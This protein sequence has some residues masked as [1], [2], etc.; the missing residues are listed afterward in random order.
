MEDK[1]SI[2]NES[3]PLGQHAIGTDMAQTRLN[4]EMMGS[5]LI[6]ACCHTFSYRFQNWYQ[7]NQR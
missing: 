5:L 1:F 2:F 3:M 4:G 6:P 7:D